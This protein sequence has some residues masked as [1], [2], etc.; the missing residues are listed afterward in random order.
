MGGD[1]YDSIKK[2]DKLITVLSDVTGHGL[3][4]ALLSSFVKDMITSYVTF[5][6]K[7]SLGAEDL[8][9]FFSK[10]YRKNRFPE[11][12]FVSIYVTV[13][14]LKRHK[15]HYISAGMQDTPL[16]SSKDHLFELKNT[17]L[18][19][20]TAIPENLYTFSERSIA[21]EPSWTILLHTD[22]ITEQSIGRDLYGDRL[23]EVFCKHSHL[24][25]STIVE[26]IKEDFKVFNN[27]SLQG[28]DDIT[29]LVMQMR[30]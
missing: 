21:L 5:T 2:G 19:I 1:F 22:G 30:G 27:G 8:L 12:Y 17:T 14:D 6:P 7:E 18:P 29:L 24:P 26:M 9:R 20:S 15:L 4:S 16:F 13:L 23:K 28:R 3:E 11:D 10:Q 25:S